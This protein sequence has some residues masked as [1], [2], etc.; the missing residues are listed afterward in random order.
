MSEPLLPEDQQLDPITAEHVESGHG[1]RIVCAAV[2]L[3]D[4]RVVCG[5]RHFDQLM[6]AM[7]PPEL[8]EAHKVL[9]GHEE[10]FVDNRYQFV[11]RNRAWDIALAAGQF[12]P[13]V[14][15]RGIRGMLF[16]ED[17]W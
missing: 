13:S 7:L 16:S 6:R 10:G 12:D 9:A 1:H 15:F 2:Q 3:K 5:V 4:G 14:N 17:V 8:A 11:D